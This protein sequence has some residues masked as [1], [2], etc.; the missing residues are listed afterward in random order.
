VDNTAPQGEVP[1]LKQDLEK[2]KTDEKAKMTDQQRE[3]FELAL[4]EIEAAMANPGL[5][6]GE[7]APD[8]T[9]PDVNGQPVQ[10]SELLKKGPVVLIFYRGAWCPYCNLQLYALKATLPRMEEL[11]AQLVAVTP[12]KVELSRQQAEEAPFSFSWMSALPGIVHNII[13]IINIT[14][15]IV[16]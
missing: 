12:Q 3:A 9:L 8:F 14:R 1:D 13:L 6:T 2:L 10:L 16:C 11:G 4:Q 5:E 7:I 15:A